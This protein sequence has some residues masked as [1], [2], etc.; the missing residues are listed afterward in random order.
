MS[1]KPRSRKLS[2]TS[3]SV[4]A[5][6]AQSSILD[7]HSSLAGLSRSTLDRLAK[8]GINSKFD[9]VLHLPL[10][11]DDE[12][13]LYALSEAPPGQP[14]L[15]E[16]K[17]VESDVKY[18]PRRQLVCH[19]EDGS[20]VLTL[21]FFN[22]YHSQV[23]QLAAGARVRAFGEI[24]HGF[25]G[26]EMVHPKYRVVQAEA[27]VARALTPVY[28]TTAGLA[29]DELRRL[30]ARALADSDLADTLPAERGRAS[31][32]PRFRDAVLLLHNPPPEIAAGHAHGQDP[33]GVAPHQ[34]RRTAG[35]ADFDAGALPPAQGGRR[36]GAE[37]AR[38]AGAGAPGAAAVQAHRRAE[39]GAR[40]DTARSRPAV[41]DAAPAAGRRRQRQDDR[42]RARGPAMRRERPPGRGDGADRDPRRAALRQIPG[43]AR[44]A[45][46][47]ASPGC[48]AASGRARSAQALARVAAGET[49]VAVG[50]HALFQEDVRFHDLALAIVDEQQRFGVHQRLQLAHERRAPEPG[51]AAAPADDER[52]AD[53][54]HA[55]DELL[56][57]SRRLGDRRD[58]AG[59]RAGHDQGFFS[60]RG[61]PR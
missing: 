35:A 24:R 19:I 33:S 47:S 28:P 54:A 44:R 10:R 31:G 30:I 22:F 56:R 49:A 25:F 18:R 21:R 12:T 37:A 8:L 40:A 43:V 45:G 57:R 51:R 42:R 17:V 52:D 48:P 16:G 55:G 46:Q 32:L 9:L 15:V 41:P 2:A 61:A 23:K 26:P 53:P 14:V 3:N 6:D 7:P 20:G 38:Q 5:Q 36:A 59:A 58:A 50:T 27:P 1:V 29:Q 11:Y 4:T 13:R 39:Q 34:V 60:T